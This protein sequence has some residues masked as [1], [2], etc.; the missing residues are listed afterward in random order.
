MANETLATIL[1]NQNTYITNGEAAR[2]ALDTK[3]TNATTQLVNDDTAL[4]KI[5]SDVELT[6][7]QLDNDDNALTLINTRLTSVLSSLDTLANRVYGYTHTAVVTDDLEKDYQ[8]IIT[9]NPDLANVSA[10][11]LLAILSDGDTVTTQGN[12]MFINGAEEQSDYSFSGENSQNGIEFVKIWYFQNDGSYINLSQK[13]TFDSVFMHIK[14]KNT[15]TIDSD[16]LNVQTVKSLG[17]NGIIY[18]AV[19]KSIEYENA[20]TDFVIPSLTKTLKSNMNVLPLNILANKIQLQNVILPELLSIEG[21]V[22]GQN[23]P[24]FYGCTNLTKITFPKLQMIGSG[25]NFA[26]TFQ[27]VPIVELPASVES[28]GEYCFGG[29]RSIILNCNKAVFKDLWCYSTP[30]ESFEMCTYWENSIRISVA[31]NNWDPE[32]FSVPAAINL[33]DTYYLYNLLKRYDYVP[34]EHTIKIP[35]RY[36]TDELIDAYVGIG[37]D[38]LGA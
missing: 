27:N 20:N 38:L 25:K 26:Q 35:T 19:I 13:F 9:S 15:I 18:T 5:K 4:A 8:D 16:N 1:Q 6:M 7:R 36:V 17:F 23:K 3:V 11:G 2:Q 12:R 28:V 10:V 32:R 29:N 33:N 34:T 14:N 31:A 22:A 30:T 37:W 21:G 24:G